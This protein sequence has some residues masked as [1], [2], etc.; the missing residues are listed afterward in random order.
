MW[1]VECKCGAENIDREGY[2]VEC[3]RFRGCDIDDTIMKLESVLDALKQL[4]THM[5]KFKGK[6]DKMRKKISKK[7]A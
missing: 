7:K 2:C 3:G 4:K 5:D 6:T 1:I